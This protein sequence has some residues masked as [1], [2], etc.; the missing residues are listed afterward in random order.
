[1]VQATEPISI[2]ITGSRIPV[3]QEQNQGTTYIIHREQIEQ[4][5]PRSVSQ[6]L[7]SVPGLYIENASTGSRTNTVYLRGAEPNYTLVLI[8]GVKVNDPSNSRGG[9]Y[10]FSLLDVNSIE[11]I[12]VVKGSYSS[13]YGSDAMAGVINIITRRPRSDFNAA[14]RAELG[15]RAFRNTSV[16]A[17]QRLG[18]GSFSLG[19]SYKDEGK[20]VDDGEYTEKSFVAKGDLKLNND[21]KVYF[22]GLYQNANSQSFPD[23]SGGSEYAII[24]SLDKTD[25]VQQNYTVGFEHRIEPLSMVK[26]NYGEFQNTENFNSPGIFGAIPAYNT[27]ADYKRHDLQVSYSNSFSGLLEMNVGMEFENEDASSKGV[28]DPF[29]FNI[30]TDFGL[31]R[32]LYAVFAETRYHIRPDLRINAGLRNDVSKQYTDRLSPRIGLQ[33]QPNNTTYYINWSEGYKLPSFFALA[34]PLVGNPDFKPESNESYEIGMR[35]KLPTMID[36]DVAAFQNTYYDLIDFGDSFVLV[37]RGEV[38]TKGVELILKKH[39]FN[40]IDWQ[41]SYTTTRFNI[42]N[43]TNTLLKRPEWLASVRLSWTQSTQLNITANANFVGPIEDYAVPTGQRTLD[44]YLKL[45]TSFNWKW[46]DNWNIQ[47]AI[48]NILNAQYQQSIGIDAPGIGVRLAV[49]AVI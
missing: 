23:D 13:I 20:Q 16:Q 6:L 34:H 43:S 42:K 44:S 19:A 35:H 48:D 27:D 36:L 8:N 1:M 14:L 11:R 26:I 30:S 28:L 7:Q 33:Y 24:Q 32:T 2:V 9:A 47:L 29:G 4:I 22:S 49:S 25:S 21:S 3:P 15:S 17:S 12:E 39:Y 45:D 46:R 37:Q 10:D 18:K 41:A 40:N 31:D 5:N 38:Q